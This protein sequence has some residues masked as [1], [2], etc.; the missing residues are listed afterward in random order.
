[1]IKYLL[2]IIWEFIRL[3]FRKKNMKILDNQLT[4][5]GIE[6]ILKNGRNSLE[7]KLDLEGEEQLIKQGLLQRRKNESV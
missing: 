6:Y 3:L 5:K 7:F 2:L 1:M 4:R